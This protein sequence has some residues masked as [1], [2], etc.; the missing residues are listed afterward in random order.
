MRLRE[1][2]GRAEDGKEAPANQE[3]KHSMSQQ[4]FWSHPRQFA[5]PE[6]MQQQI[7]SKAPSTGGSDTHRPSC[8]SYRAAPAM[9]SYLSRHPRASARIKLVASSS[10]QPALL[11][12]S[13]SVDPA[14]GTEV[15]HVYLADPALEVSCPTHHSHEHTLYQKKQRPAPKRIGRVVSRGTT[16]KHGRSGSQHVHHPKPKPT[17][18]EEKTSVASQQAI[19]TQWKETAVDVGLSNAHAQLERSSSPP[20]EV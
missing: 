13:R 4:H 2:A 17:P 3:P 16:M 19:F 15:I 18:E 6:C 8:C 9:P 7:I 5:R 14:R 10:S 1:G 12:H 20:Q 11:T